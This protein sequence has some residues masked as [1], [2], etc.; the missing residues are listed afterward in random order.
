[1]IGGIC[2]L[3]NFPLLDKERQIMGFIVLAVGLIFIMLV[4]LKGLQ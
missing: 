1:M 3:G 2:I 4:I